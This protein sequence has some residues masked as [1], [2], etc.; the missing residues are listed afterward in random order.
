MDR[1][2]IKLCLI[3]AVITSITV[4]LLG[5]F[6]APDSSLLVL[7][8]IGAVLGVVG[9]LTLVNQ[10]DKLQERVET[11]LNSISKLDQ[12]YDSETREFF[13]TDM[14]EQFVRNHA[15][16]IANNAKL[17]RTIDSARIAVTHDGH[18]LGFI[19]NKF[20]DTMIPVIDQF[21]ADITIRA[22][23]HTEE[24]FRLGVSI[25]SKKTAAREA[26]KKALVACADL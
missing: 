11:Q 9:A 14:D 12:P 10:I 23:I 3:G 4:M 19:D 24:K 5:Y 17:D 25:R 16:K 18:L 6:I 13:L 1:S 20:N 7:G 15:Q 26:L 2:K 21:A 22:R 8:L